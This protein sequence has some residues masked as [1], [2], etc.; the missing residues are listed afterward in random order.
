MLRALGIPRWKM[1]G[2]VVAQSL[3]VGI[4]GVGLGV[5]AVYSLAEGAAAL[6]AK[7][8][9]SP[10]LVAAAGTV[11]LI[12]ALVSGLVALRSLR[13]AEPATLLR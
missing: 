5:P 10:W 6:G 8:L 13:L 12:M 11:T 4:L 2:M 3:W 1:R 9:L 7:V